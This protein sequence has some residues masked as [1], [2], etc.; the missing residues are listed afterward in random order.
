MTWW[1]PSL[2]TAGFNLLPIC[3]G[4]Q[5]TLLLLFPTCVKLCGRNCW[6]AEIK[7]Q[8]WF[9]FCPSA[10][11]VYVS[12][13]TLYENDGQSFLTGICVGVRM[14]PW[15]HCTFVLWHLVVCICGVRK[16]L[17]MNISEFIFFAPL[18]SR[19]TAAGKCAALASTVYLKIING[20]SCIECVSWLIS[21]NIC[22]S[23]PVCSERIY[24]AWCQLC[25]KCERVHV[26]TSI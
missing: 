8:L 6:N 21:G 2:K 7:G 14:S 25:S 16:R 26:V 19:P 24:F 1:N 15:E 23:M 4:I 13:I 11:T 12:S 20:C 9:Y 10:C 22:L 17:S 18:L 5:N 3:S